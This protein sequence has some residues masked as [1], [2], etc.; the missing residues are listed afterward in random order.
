MVRVPVRPVPPERRCGS[1]GVL[2]V[3]GSPPFLLRLYP[4]AHFELV[5]VTGGLTR[6]F[7]GLVHA[8]KFPAHFVSTHAPHAGAAPSA[9]HGIKHPVATHVE[10][11]PK[12]AEHC[13]LSPIRFATH[14]DTQLGSVKT[15]AMQGVPQATSIA[16][17][18][19]CVMGTYAFTSEDP[20]ALPTPTPACGS[21][22]EG[23]GDA[24]DAGMARASRQKTTRLLICCADVRF[25]Q[26]SRDP[27]C[28]AGAGEEGAA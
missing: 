19:T 22:G 13:V 21:E 24:D 9:K 7:I 6:T 18:P 23:D 11:V 4:P 14:L 5:H 25:E 1:V 17:M 8:L 28:K 16:D 15:T 3:K 2:V 12:H 26:Y 27:V 20:H 10:N